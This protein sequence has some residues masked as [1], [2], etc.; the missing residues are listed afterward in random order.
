MTLYNIT[1]LLILEWK[2]ML[3]MFIL[4]KL[5]VSTTAMHRKS[6]F[7]FKIRSVISQSST[8]RLF[9]NIK[10]WTRKR[11]RIPGKALRPSGK[12]SISAGANG[13]ACTTTKVVGCNQGYISIECQH[14]LNGLDHEYPEISAATSSKPLMQVLESVYI[15]VH[16]R[17]VEIARIQSSERV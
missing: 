14:Y 6:F 12:G 11:K 7:G 9:I 15:E 3:C 8:K 13:N 1:I 2:K 16:F 5:V 10:T 17:D 4:L